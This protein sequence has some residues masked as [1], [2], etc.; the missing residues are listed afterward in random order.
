M[1]IFTKIF[2]SN[3][4]ELKRLEPDVKKINN[5]F[6]T[7]KD[8]K[9]AEIKQKVVDLKEKIEKRKIDYTADKGK[10]QKSLIDFMP[11]MFA[12]VK[13]ASKK[14]VG[15]THF[16]VQLLAG[17][18]LFKGNLCEVATGEGK[19]FAATLP[20]S[21]YALCG[22]GAHCVTVNDY[23]ARR[24]AEWAGNIY[25]SLGLTVAVNTP[26][27]AYKFVPDSELPPE[28]LEQKKND[29]NYKS[30]FPIL[31]RMHGLNLV[32]CTKHEAYNCDITYSTNNEIGFDYL[33]DNMARSKSDMVQRDYFFCIVDEADSILIDESRTPLI[34]SSPVEES[35]ELYV[36]FA[37]IAR[38]LQNEVDYTIDEKS[39]SVNLTE[40]GNDKVEKIVG[41]DN[42]WENYSLAHHLEN[43]LKAK[44]LF[45]KDKE[46]LVYDGQIVIVDKFTGRLMQGRRF[47]EGIHQSI[48]AK[49]GVKI[50]NE[51]QTFATIT[52]QNYFRLYKVLSGM[53]GTALTEAEEFNKIYKLDVVVIPTN[54]P[55]VRKDYSDVVFK[56][57][58]GKFKAVIKE[59]K[60]KNETGQPVLVG[61]TSVENSEILSEMLSK[62]GVKHNVLNAKYFEKEAE[63][64]AN[65][66]HIGQV[67]I[68]TNMAG[69]GTDISLE[70]GVIEL[71]GLHIIGTER[72]EARRID[73]QLRGRAGRQG[74]PGS[75]RFYVAL[76][77]EIMRLFGG[78]TVSKIM[79]GFGISEDLPIESG[80]LSKQIESAQK[81]VEGSNF[82]VRKNLVEYDDVLN[83]QR[84]IFYKKRRAVLD[85]FE[86]DESLSEDEKEEKYTAA[87][88]YVLSK[89]NEV[90]GNII[91][92]NS[93]DS[94]IDSDQF[95][96]IMTEFENIVPKELIDLT[97]KTEGGSYD[98][99]L[100]L[101][102]LKRPIISEMLKEQIE[103]ILEEC[104]NYHCEI[105]TPQVFAQVAKDTMLG[106]M[107]YLWMQHLE[108]VDSLREGIF[109]RGYAQQVPLVE[110][111]NEVYNL[112][113][114]LMTSTDADISKRLFKVATTSTGID[115]NKLITEHIQ[116]NIQTLTQ[117]QP[118]EEIG[119]IAPL[120]KEDFSKPINN[121]KPT[122][123]EKV[124]Q[125]T[126]NK[127]V[128]RND[129]C[130][131][132]SGKK[133]KK[134]HMLSDQQSAANN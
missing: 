5:L 70:K 20:L 129:P 75:S 57:S 18:E 107:D 110:Y 91:D 101:L 23:L 2:D 74:D 35:S 97:L 31:N 113:D 124:R 12:L 37:Q 7:Y 59:I 65:A 64:I 47:N 51:S 103:I 89:L 61:T 67:T 29:D 56:N 122:F 69:R 119:N 125:V 8:L 128:G 96:T 127:K 93:N 71:G 132:G 76:D 48:E 123:Q 94:E 43:A 46:Y 108:A 54:Q 50:Q 62:V 78:N 21:F 28:I 85:T 22:R 95:T 24:D 6:E 109:L 36:K 15:I 10:I 84:E 16:D 27:A 45:K 86:I 104:Y 98:E 42:I 79:G 100:K 88:E 25:N 81:K 17:I 99:W 66:G 3:D 92:I 26:K 58:S 4:K 115:I 77:D 55:M 82:D 73:N 114:T 102:T 53:T 60:E 118:Q 30:K 11:E 33:R 72:H 38:T 83:I 131:C 19:T 39:N 133:Y 116:A 111:K 105:I 120:R 121:P 14:S 63:I 40:S 130:P 44:E 13:A 9:P 52:F 80:I 1:A 134:C 112:F 90:I 68:A 49:E 117:N 126:A 32:E 87:K 34:I 41:T 106:T